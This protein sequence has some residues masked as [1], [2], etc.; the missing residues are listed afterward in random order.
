VHCVS[1]FLYCRDDL[2]ITK[3]ANSTESI[4]R[5][6]FHHRQ[7][8]YEGW[9]SFYCRTHL[10]KYRWVNQAGQLVEHFQHPHREIYWAGENNGENDPE[11]GLHQKRGSLLVSNIQCDWH[12]TQTTT[13]AAVESPSHHCWTGLRR[14]PNHLVSENHD[15]VL[16][17]WKSTSRHEAHIRS[18]WLTSNEKYP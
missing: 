13:V 5:M 14:L 18:C 9:D 12:A 8:L 2:R 4:R 6:H 15:S 17:L 16:S 7:A 10:E 11:L 3:I 1:K